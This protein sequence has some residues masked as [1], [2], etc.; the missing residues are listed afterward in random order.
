[1]P[2]GTMELEIVEVGPSSRPLQYV[3]RP[4]L[5]PPPPPPPPPPLQQQQ[6]GE[7]G[8]ANAAPPLVQHFDSEKL[9][10]TLVSEIRPF[11]RAANDIEAENPRVAYLYVGVFFYKTFSKDESSTKSKMTQR[12]DAREMKSFYE[13]KKKANAHEHLPVLAEV[14]KALLSGTG[15]EVGLVASEDF[16]DLFRYNILPLHPRSSQKPIMLLPE[17]IGE[18]AL[19]ERKGL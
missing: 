10:Q 8:D 1:M 15:L 17:W 4:P 12:G 16:A 19:R 14:L 9:P 2:R 3:S 6:Q 5:P 7:A 13:K 18:I 11:L